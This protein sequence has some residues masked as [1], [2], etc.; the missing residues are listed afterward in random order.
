[1][2]YKEGTEDGLVIWW[3]QDGKKKCEKSFKD[4]QL[5]GLWT[6]WSEDGKKTYEKH[7]VNGNQQ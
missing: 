1:M 3:Y 5:N 6:E 2:H 7:F 4:R